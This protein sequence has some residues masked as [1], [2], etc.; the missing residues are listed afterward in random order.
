MDAM[1][2][3]YSV[4]V[5]LN[6]FFLSFSNVVK[7]SSSRKMRAGRWYG[8]EACYA[9][10]KPH[11]AHQALLRLHHRCHRLSSIRKL[12]TCLC[13]LFYFCA[14][15]WPLVPSFVIDFKHSLPTLFCIFENHSN[16]RCHCL[17]LICKL[18]FPT[19]VRF[20]DQQHHCLSSITKSKPICFPNRGRTQIT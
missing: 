8:C 17:S 15:Y 18:L 3:H 20:I 4:M 16:H 1:L 12:Q 7:S 19:Y 13:N 5:I 9:M 14:L 10:R 2:V 11:P 6:L